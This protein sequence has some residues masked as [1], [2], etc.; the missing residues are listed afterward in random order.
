MDSQNGKVVDDTKVDKSEVI[1]KVDLNGTERD[2]T[3]KMA[4]IQNP[5]TGDTINNSESENQNGAKYSPVK[6]VDV[7]IR[8]GGSS[9]SPFKMAETQ[10]KNGGKSDSPIKMADISSQNGEG[11]LEV[12]KELL[13]VPRTHPTGHRKSFMEEECAKERLRLSLLKQCSAILKQ[14]E[15]R[16][17]KEALHRTFQDEV[18]DVLFYKL[19]TTTLIIFSIEK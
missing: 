19:P 18:S 7:E 14:G 6:M 4:D 3:V 16:Y 13:A 11:R 5:K 8:K 1:I 15:A 17:T 2:N 12:S 10:F 9:D